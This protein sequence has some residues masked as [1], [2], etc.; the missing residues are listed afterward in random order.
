MCG[1]PTQTD[2]IMFIDPHALEI[3]AVIVTCPLK[4]FCRV[5]KPVVGLI[6]NPL[7]LLLVHVILSALGELESE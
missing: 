4:L 1:V 5:A 3:V 2:R 7:I 6:V